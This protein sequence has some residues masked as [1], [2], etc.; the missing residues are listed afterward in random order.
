MTTSAPRVYGPGAG[1]VVEGQLAGPVAAAGCLL[2]R[3]RGHEECEV[4]ADAERVEH[5][6]E[7]DDRALFVSV[8]AVRLLVVRVEQH[9]PSAAVGDHLLEVGE[10]VRGS[11]RARARQGS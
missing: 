8:R 3:V 11:N 9:E 10:L 6:E 1:D 4:V 2:A 7:V 5:A